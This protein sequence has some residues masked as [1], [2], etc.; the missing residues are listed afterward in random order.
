MQLLASGESAEW[1]GD[2][3]YLTRVFEGAGIREDSVLAEAV[4]W[5]ATATMGHAMID[6][7]GR[8]H[9]QPERLRASLERL[10]PEDAA[11][12]A[13]LIPHFDDMRDRGFELVVELTI[14]GLEQLLSR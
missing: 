13:R 2:S 3:A 10:D 11:L 1:L 4:Y 8:D 7:A 5:V 9:L 12:T 6:A 14:A